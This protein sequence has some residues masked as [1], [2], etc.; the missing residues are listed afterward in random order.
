[1]PALEDILD[2]ARPELFFL[3]FI[4]LWA[5]ISY[6]LSIIGGWAKLAEDY[7]SEPLM[8]RQ[9]WTF[10]SAAMRFAAS[11]NNVLTVGV[12]DAGL[13]LSIFFLFRLGHP[14]LLIPWS[15]IRKVGEAGKFKGQRL[16]IAK[17]PSIP[18]RF[19]SKLIDKIEVARGQPIE[20]VGVFEQ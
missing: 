14:P 15:D 4:V 18:L 11:Y 17:A 3:G 20:Q 6:L 1:M 10:Q 19:R 8:E 16:R 9:R 7:R 5:T 2:P 13:S 12:S